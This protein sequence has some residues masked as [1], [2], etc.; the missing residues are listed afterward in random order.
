MLSCR[1][2]SQRAVISRRA[3]SSEICSRA[4]S[5]N[6]SLLISISRIFFV[7]SDADINGITV[8]KAEYTVTYMVDGEIATAKNKFDLAGIGDNIEVEV[9]VKATGKGNYTGEAASCYYTITREDKSKDLSKAK[10]V[11]Q[12][13]GDTTHKA[14]TKFEFTGKPIEIG[15]EDSEYEFYVYFGTLKNPTAVLS[16]ADYQVEYTNNVKA[17]TATV[18]ITGDGVN[19]FGGKNATFKIV[20]GT[21]LWSM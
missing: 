11:I 16:D 2:L 8:P 20:T 19:Y 9:V 21:M 4:L 12:K 3:S 5:A 18:M 13:K 17:G 7:T 15:T 10:I 1:L 6:A 14:V